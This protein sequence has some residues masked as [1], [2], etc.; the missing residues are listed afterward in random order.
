MS[1]DIETLNALVDAAIREGRA[2]G[3]LDPEPWAR[4]PDGPS[5]PRSAENDGGFLYWRPR[6]KHERENVQPEEGDRAR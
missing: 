3:S 1:A 2:S 6:P 5:G 4:F